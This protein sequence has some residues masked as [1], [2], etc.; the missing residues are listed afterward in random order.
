MIVQSIPIN[1]NLPT[2]PPDIGEVPNTAVAIERWKILERISED[3]DS[4]KTQLKS[5]MQSMLPPEI[6]KSL[7]RS[8][9]VEGWANVCKSS[10][11][12]VR[13]YPSTY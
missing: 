7:E 8:K 3:F 6:F 4:A 13:L 5:K 1:E 9:G 11:R 10:R 2:D 12:C